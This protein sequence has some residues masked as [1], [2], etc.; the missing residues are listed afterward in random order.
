MRWGIREDEGVWRKQRKV[1]ER[2]YA[3]SSKHFRGDGAQLLL[4]ER[5]PSD[6]NRAKIEDFT[7]GV[8]PSKKGMHSF[9]FPRILERDLVLRVMLDDWALAWNTLMPVAGMRAPRKPIEQITTAYADDYERVVFLH[10]DPR[11]N[12][13]FEGYY[14]KAKR[15]VMAMAAISRSFLRDPLQWCP[16]KNSAGSKPASGSSIASKE[17]KYSSGLINEDLH[18]QHLSTC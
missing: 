13:P 3:I 16:E 1:G 14:Q 6:R 9:S 17:A 2:C 5:P 4:S 11:D 7:A 15:D 8:V 10:A 12:C 18:G